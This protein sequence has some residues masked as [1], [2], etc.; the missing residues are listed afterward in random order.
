MKTVFGYIVVILLF[1]GLVLPL[2][3]DKTEKYEYKLE[4]KIPSIEK[5]YIDSSNNKLDSIVDF[6][7]RN[8]KYLEYEIKRM[9]KPDTITN[10]RTPL[11]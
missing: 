1:A 10:I 2:Q 6:S 8:L 7:E 3:S 11:F 5:S 4:Y 9:S